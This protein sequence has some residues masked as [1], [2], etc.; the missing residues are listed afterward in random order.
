MER[1]FTSYPGGA[2]LGAATP[3]NYNFQFFLLFSKVRSFPTMATTM[4][5]RALSSIIFSH[6]RRFIKELER[7]TSYMTTAARAC[8]FL[9]NNHYKIQY[10]HLVWQLFSGCCKTARPEK[11]KMILTISFTVPKIKCVGCV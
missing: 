7:V 8:L 1:F 5:L 4:S 2:S 6:F 9:N 11:N 3:K 10:E